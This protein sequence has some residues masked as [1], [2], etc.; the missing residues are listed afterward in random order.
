MEHGYL[1]CW[2]PESLPLAEQEKV[3]VILGTLELG[4]EAMK[5]DYGQYFKV[6]K[7]RWTGCSN[8]FAVICAQ[9]GVGSF[10]TDVT[11]KPNVLA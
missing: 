10:A 6:C 1:E 9:K 8:E 4:L 11:V 3:A 2:L 5:E 7:R